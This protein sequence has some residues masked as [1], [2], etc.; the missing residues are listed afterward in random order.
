MLG[1]QEEE[2]SIYAKV[3]GCYIPVL[4]KLDDQAFLD[5][6]SSLDFSCLSI[7]ISARFFLCSHSFEFHKPI[8][9]KAFKGEN[10]RWM[11]Q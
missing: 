4:Q 9:Q 3:K 6:W 2:L 7:S 10:I 11:V 1:K 5:K 8:L